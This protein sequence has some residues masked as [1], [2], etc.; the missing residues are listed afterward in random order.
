[1]WEGEEGE[2]ERE[3]EE[4]KEG[5]RGPRDSGRWPLL[6]REARKDTSG[7]CRE[8]KRGSQ[9]RRHERVKGGGVTNREKE[10]EREREREREG[11]GGGGEGGNASVLSETTLRFSQTNNSYGIHTCYTSTERERERGEGGKKGNAS[12]LSETILRFSQTNN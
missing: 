3:E 12:V 6:M 11:G 5:E 2:G 1:M 4:E 9:K 8:R 7:L 10:I